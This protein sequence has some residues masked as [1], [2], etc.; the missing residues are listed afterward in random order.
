[1]NRIKAYP[2]HASIRNPSV[3]SP[4][5]RFG[6]KTQKADNSFATK[7]DKSIYSRQKLAVLHLAANK[8]ADDANIRVRRN[9]HCKR[10]ARRE[11]SIT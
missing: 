6:P 9:L 3:I 1:M 4:C 7:L 10:T 8:R 2:H 5:P 11:R